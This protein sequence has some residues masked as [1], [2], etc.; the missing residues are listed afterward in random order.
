MAIFQERLCT[1]G[2][3]SYASRVLYQRASLQKNV[4]LNTMEG[5]RVRD[6]LDAND[7][8]NKLPRACLSPSHQYLPIFPPT[9][10]VIIS[11]ISELYYTA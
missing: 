5:E 3:T 4:E 11:S 2:E 7:E 6:G 1:L 8:L 9:D 10:V